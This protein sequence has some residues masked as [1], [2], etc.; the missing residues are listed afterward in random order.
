MKQ[1]KEA[2]STCSTSFKE[3]TKSLK[4]LDHLPPVAFVPKKGKKTKQKDGF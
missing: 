3:F 4:P 1:I 2:F